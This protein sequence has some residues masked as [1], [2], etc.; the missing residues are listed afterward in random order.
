MILFFSLSLYGLL[1]VACSLFL[2]NVRDHHPET[3][4]TKIQEA[5]E[6]IG[7]NTTLVGRVSTLFG[8]ND[9][10]PLTNDEALLRN[11]HQAPRASRKSAHTI[12]SSLSDG[13]DEDFPV[14]DDYSRQIAELQQQSTSTPPKQLATTPAHLNPHRLNDLSE[15]MTQSRA[16][17]EALQR[18]GLSADSFSSEDEGMPLLEGDHDRRASNALETAAP[19]QLPENVFASSVPLRNMIGRAGELDR[20]RSGG[21][22]SVKSYYSNAT[23]MRIVDEAEAADV[24]VIRETQKVRRLKDGAAELL[25]VR[26]VRKWFGWESEGAWALDGINFAVPYPQ[27]EEVHNNEEHRRAKNVLG[28]GFLPTGKGVFGL[29]GRN[30]AGKTT[31]LRLLLRLEKPSL[32]EISI[33]GDPSR[34]DYSRVGYCPQG[35]ESMLPSLSVFETLRFYGQLRLLSFYSDHL[36]EKLIDCL[37]LT[38]FSNKKAGHLSAGNQRKLCFAVSLLGEPDLLLLDEPTVGIDLFSK[39]R[40]WSLI[41]RYG[42]KH[43]VLMTTNNMEEGQELSDQVAI[44]VSGQW[45]C[46]GDVGDFQK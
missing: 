24:G 7:N 21:A 17:K 35:D 27:Q 41:S 42:K 40:I 32:G 2:R 26:N 16:R 38:A 29:L 12:R 37:Q 6:Y 13:G 14:A 5:H 22:Q 31:L 11:A 28:G 36:I 44:Q 15:H 9:E 45:K 8:L 19:R 30:G 33:F 10:N 39:Q 23:S 3:A 43:L 4:Q 46:L 18:A 25:F 34:V 1:L 20:R